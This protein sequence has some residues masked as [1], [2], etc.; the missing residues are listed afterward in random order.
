MLLTERILIKPNHSHHKGVKALC[1][2][3]ATI[4]NQALYYFRQAFFNHEPIKWAQVDKLMK[5]RHSDKYD[6]IPN[7]IS[8]Q[9]IKKIGTDFKAFWQAYK[10]WQS[11]PENFKAKPRIPHYQKLKT[12]IQPAQGVSIRDG[13][14]VFPKKLGL[15]PIKIHCVNE[16]AV[17][18][19]SDN[20]VVKELRYVPHGS[21]F[22]LEIVYEQDK[23]LS[24]EHL[25]K[26]KTKL[27][28][29]NLFSLDLGIN[30]LVTLVSNKPGFT[31]ILF[32][33]TPVKSL[34]QRFNKHKAELQS[35]GH[36]RVI[37]HQSVKRFCQIS[38]YFHKVSHEIIEQ[39]LAEDV[40]KLVIGINPGWKQQVNIGKVNNQKFVSI[41]FQSLIDKITYKAKQFGIEVICQEESYTSKADALACDNLPV[42]GKVKGKPVF[43]GRRTKRGLYQSSVGKLINADVNGAINILRKVIGNDFVQGLLDKGAVFAPMRWIPAH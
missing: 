25:N 26:R 8:Q 3:T 29:N 41:P 30:N 31:P 16:Q 21:C 38:D 11:H 14:L 37:A 9:V 39:C 23:V 27:N 2:E 42:Y 1:R 6:A 19:K 5:V 28:A 15:I 43:S 20:A 32:S 12:A 7:A 36:G 40:G 24:Q 4:T 22:W 33:G 34:N 17:L 18:T 35:S 10:Q 13:H